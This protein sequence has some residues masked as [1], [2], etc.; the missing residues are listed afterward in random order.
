MINDGL[1]DNF[2]MESVW[3]LHNWPGLDVGEIAVHKGPVMASFDQFRVLING[4]G[5]HAASP[6]H[7]SD[8]ILLLLA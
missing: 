5:G 7:A 4:V 8:P 1:F 3:G 6:H 2:P